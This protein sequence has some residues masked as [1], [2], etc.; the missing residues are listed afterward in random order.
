MNDETQIIDQEVPNRPN[1]LPSP[2]QELEFHN[3]L[4]AGNEKELYRWI[5]RQLQSME[6]RGAFAVQYQ[7]LAAQLTSKIDHALLA[8][9]IDT[10]DFQVF[11]SQLASCYTIAQYKLLFGYY[12]TLAVELM[13]QHKEDTDPIVSFV[14]DYLE[15][16]YSNDVSLEA[17][18]D[19]LKITG[20]YLS[21][22]FK[23]KTGLNFSDYL[24]KLRIDRAKQ[25]LDNSDEKV[26]SV[27]SQ[28]GYQNVN[29]FIRMFKKITELTPGE[30]KKAASDAP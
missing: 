11:R 25:I 12:L 18:A 27:A 5:E 7:Q 16:H 28:V 13:K 24:N 9:Q 29:S 3:H 17:V 22:Y 19:K 21:T 15:E 26:K 30:Y 23:E 14:M 1:L 10:A 8:L 2:E 4:M 6:R 20:G